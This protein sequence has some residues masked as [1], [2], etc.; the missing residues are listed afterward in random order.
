MN[1][2]N[3]TPSFLAKVLLSIALKWTP[4]IRQILSSLNLIGGFQISLG[5]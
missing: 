4:E 5:A 3:E 2:I 1:A